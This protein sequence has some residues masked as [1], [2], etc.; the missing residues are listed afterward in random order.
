MTQICVQQ[1]LVS[2]SYLTTTDCYVVLYHTKIR[3]HLISLKTNLSFLTLF[4]TEIKGRETSFRSKRHASMR[5]KFTGRKTAAHK[6]TKGFGKARF[7]I[8]EG[9]K[10]SA[11]CREI[12]HGPV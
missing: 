11:A 7:S 8:L 4:C 2:S 5:H 9:L 10:I 3:I 6:A 12:E 1:F